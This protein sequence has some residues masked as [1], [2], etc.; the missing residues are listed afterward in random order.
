MAQGQ[1][2]NIKL[3]NDDDDDDDDDND[4]D[5]DGDDDDDDDNMDITMTIT[6]ILQYIGPIW[7]ELHSITKSLGEWLDFRENDNPLV[8][9]RCWTNTSVTRWTNTIGDG[10][11]NH[12][13][14]KGLNMTGHNLSYSAIGKL[15]D[16]A[17]K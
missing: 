8:T 11:R 9:T 16:T 10:E 2:S 7:K 12:W 13:V 1:N 15:F 6:L 4:D 3:Y 5:D 17:A 14:T